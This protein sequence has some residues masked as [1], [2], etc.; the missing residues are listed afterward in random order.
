M[1]RRNTITTLLFLLLTA[2]GLALVLTAF[3]GGE[4]K[5]EGLLKSAVRERDPGAV[6]SEA[7]S[8]VNS[9]LDRDH[10]FIQLYGGVQRLSGRRVIQDMVAGNTVAKLSTGALNFVNLGTAGQV[11][12]E[13][14][15]RR[16]QAT[17]E[18]AAKLE[19]RGIPY[20][21]IAA[22][23]KIQRGAELLPRGLEESGN[24]TCDAYL[25]ELDRLGVDYLDLRPVFESNGIY[26][27]WFFRTDHHWKPEA[28][29]FAW[30]YLSGELDLRY[31]YETP[32]ILTNPNNW[33]TRVLDDFFL[34]SQG[35]RVGSLYAGVDDFTIYT[36]KFDTNL[37]YT[38]SDGSFDRSGPFA[39]SVCFPERVEERD[40]FNG[41]PYTYYS[42]GDYAMATMV[43]H[44][45]PKGPKVVLLRE[46][47]SCALAPFL[48]L[49]CSELTTID[50]RYFSGDLMDTIRELEPDLVLTLYTASSTGLDNM[51]NF[52][53]TE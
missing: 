11:D 37:T 12:Q 31:G 23:Q 25:A 35:K 50:L 32:S 28:A 8:A 22:P 19:V 1:K 17:A 41:N 48:A 18:L 13:A 43:N 26:S 52:D 46:S 36:P 49:S 30:Q 38:N 42:G 34:G 2:A 14:V 44:N 10:L 21:Y 40:W 3:V 47:F 29:F 5:L 6:L 4:G 53:T 27:N 20:L 39:Q 33:S 45:N 24:A 9:D 15:G 7:E 51:F 16:A